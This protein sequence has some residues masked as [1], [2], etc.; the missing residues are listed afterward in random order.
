MQTKLKTNKRLIEENEEEITQLKN[1]N[2]KAARDI[3]ELG[4]Q[5]DMLTREINALRSKLR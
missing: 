3:D 4:E 1:R 2:R 5:N